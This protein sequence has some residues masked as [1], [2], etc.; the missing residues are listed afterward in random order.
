MSN[1]EL[2]NRISK[3]VSEKLNALQ[4]K[5]VNMEKDTRANQVSFSRVTEKQNEINGKLERDAKTRDMMKELKQQMLLQVSVSTFFIFIL[6]VN[7]G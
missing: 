7:C 3:I 5:L 4:E 6:T 1:F 2:D